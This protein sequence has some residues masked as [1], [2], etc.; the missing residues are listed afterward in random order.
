MKKIFSI[1]ALAL[2]SACFA[3]AAERKVAVQTFTC[4]SYTLEDICTMFSA[5]GVKNIEL[6]TGHLIGGKYPKTRFGV[7]TL[8]ESPEVFKYVRDMFD[9]HGLKVVSTGVHYPKNEAEVEEICKFSKALGAEYVSAESPDAIVKLWLKHLDGLKLTIHNHHALPFADP[10]YVA[11]L[12]APYPNV[13]ACA[14][15][16]GWTRAGFDSVQGLKILKGKIFTIH[17]KDQEKL[18]NKSSNAKIYGTGCIDLKGML[19]ELDA[20]KFDGYIIIEHGN[21]DDKYQVIKRDM[22]FLKNN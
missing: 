4:Y 2:V 6:C 8:K 12:V 17:L 22:Q 15:N 14:D 5:L 13:G 1:L 16:G 9:K 19:A 21:Y 18:G 3:F 7:K 10:N 11:K 20:Q